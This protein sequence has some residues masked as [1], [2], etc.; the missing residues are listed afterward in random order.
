MTYQSQGVNQGIDLQ[1]SSLQANP[2]PVVQSE[3]VTQPGGDNWGWNVSEYDCAPSAAVLIAIAGSDACA[4][5]AP[6]GSMAQAASARARRSV[7]PT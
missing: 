2:L 1:Y 4:E 3:P 6:M 5:A 7:R